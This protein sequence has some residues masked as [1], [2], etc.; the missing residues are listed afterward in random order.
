[1]MRRTLLFAALAVSAAVVAATALASKGTTRYPFVQ[2]SNNGLLAANGAQAIVS[3]TLQCSGEGATSFTV[4]VNLAQG[5]TGGQGSGT[6]GCISGV[7]AAWTLIVTPSAG[8]YK[9]GQAS[10]HIQAADDG[11]RFN[12]SASGDDQISLGSSF[13]SLEVPIVSG[14]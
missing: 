2:V 1:M 6:F 7:Q 10:V 9:G 3:G 14:P 8:T 4:Q 12:T 11:V 5:T 13:E